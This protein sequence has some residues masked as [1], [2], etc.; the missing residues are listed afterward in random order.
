MTNDSSDDNV[1]SLDE[2]SSVPEAAEV[3]PLPFKMPDLMQTIAPMSELKRSELRDAASLV[4]T[5]LAGALADGR[6]VILPDF[7]KI[8]PKGNI[9]KPGGVFIKAKIKLVDNP[10]DTSDED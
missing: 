2:A 3:G 8:S 7:G 9:T 4:L 1:I 10:G 6:E 5:A